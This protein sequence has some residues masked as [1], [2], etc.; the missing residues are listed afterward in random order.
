[1]QRRAPPSP[2]SKSIRGEGG[3]C[4]AHV[5]SIGPGLL[6][7]FC[8]VEDDTMQDAARLATK[9]TKLRIFEDGDFPE[10]P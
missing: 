6:V 4:P 3:D 2:G 1:M 7:L 9:I 8:S 10:G 5:G